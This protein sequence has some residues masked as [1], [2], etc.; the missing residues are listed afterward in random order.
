MYTYYTFMRTN[1]RLCPWV[2]P[3]SLMFTGATIHLQGPF[4]TLLIGEHHFKSMDLELDPSISYVTST[5]DYKQG[6]S[7]STLLDMFVVVLAN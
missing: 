3:S 4:M 2:C 1:F 6:G 5:N 7:I